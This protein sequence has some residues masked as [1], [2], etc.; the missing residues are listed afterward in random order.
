MLLDT[1]SPSIW[2]PSDRVDRNLWVG[3][4]LLNVAQASSLLVGRDAFHQ[5]YGSGSVAGVK[6]TV[7]MNFGGMLIQNVPF[8]LVLA[9]D[10]RLYGNPFDGIIGL[11]RRSINPEN[12]NS[13][14]HS[15]N[16]QGLMSRKFG[17]YFRDGGSTFVMGDNL[18]QLISDPVIY[19]NVVEGPYWETRVTWIFIDGS[20]FCTE[21]HR[22]ILDTG[23]SKINLPGDIHMAINNVLGIWRKMQNEYVFDCERLADLPPITFQIQGKMLQIMPRQYTEQTTTNGVTTC[24]T[25]FQNTSSGYP[26]G[27][28]LGMSFL[29]SFQLIFDDHAGTVGFSERPG[30][31]S[32][33]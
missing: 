7:H 23:T 11:G 33:S 17:F 25:R 13:L 22:M 32:I 27:I 18:V 30:R 29:H 15:L 31:S 19:V 14:F 24:Y 12:S 21:D 10:E 9:G 20:G 1:G 4:S 16:Q 28:I 5:R 8:G 26:V 6:A 3:K 2:V